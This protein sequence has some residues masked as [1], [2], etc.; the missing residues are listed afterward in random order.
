M[1]FLRF[2]LVLMFALFCLMQYQFW[3]RFSFAIKFIFV[4]ILHR[5]LIS[6]FA[7]DKLL[8]LIDFSFLFMILVL[9]L[10]SDSV[11]ILV[12]AFGTGCALNPDFLMLN[13]NW[14]SIVDFS[15]ILVW[16]LTSFGI[17]FWFLI[18]LCVIN[19]LCS[20]TSF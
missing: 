9:T 18:S 7:L 2:A 17:W 14:G 11:F 3:T 12:L 19:W 4:L 1:I 13:L 20:W 8:L 16:H 5:N 10:G 15:S 6:R